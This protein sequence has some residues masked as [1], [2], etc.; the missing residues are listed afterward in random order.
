VRRPPPRLDAR[1][2]RERLAATRATHYRIAQLAGTSP[3][4]VKDVAAGRTRTVSRAYADALSAAI[5]EAESEVASNSMTVVPHDIRFASTMR[6][7]RGLYARV[8]TRYRA[9]QKAGELPG[10]TEREEP[11]DENAIAWCSSR[12]SLL[13]FATFYDVGLARLWIDVLWVDPR[14]RRQGIGRALIAAI[15]LHV[16]ADYRL[17]LGTMTENAAMHR[18]ADTIGFRP[19]STTYQLSPRQEL[20]RC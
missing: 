5:A 20:P 13:G 8:M 18:L 11:T 19:I 2:L 12:T 4:F 1:T 17:L 15:R 14:H 16:S 10:P 3:R 7:E 9:A 6:S